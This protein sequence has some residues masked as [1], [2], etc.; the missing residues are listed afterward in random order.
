MSLKEGISGSVRAALAD[1]GELAAAAPG[2]QLDL[3]AEAPPSRFAADGA[4]LGTRRTLNQVLQARGHGRPKGAQNL[5]TRD[6]REFIRRVF[7]DPMLETGRWAL[8]TP[9]TLAKELGC[10]LLEAFDRLQG[11]RE[12]LLPYFYAKLAP[13]D[14]DG[15]AVV[16]QFAMVIGGQIMGQERPPWMDDPDVRRAIEQQQQNQGVTGE[17]AQNSHAQNSHDA[18]TH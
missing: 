2:E 5:A 3:L 17:P 9:E 4:E 1:L 16:P 15:R 11:L 7:G 14:N 6:M 8:H 18:P 12:C 10:S 13:V